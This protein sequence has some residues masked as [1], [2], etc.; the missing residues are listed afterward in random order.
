MRNTT[1]SKRLSSCDRSASSAQRPFH[2]LPKLALTQIIQGLE[3]LL[4]PQLFSVFGGLGSPSFSYN[5][6]LHMF[7]LS[8]SNGLHSAHFSR[9]RTVMRNRGDIPDCRYFKAL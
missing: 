5:T 4:F 7:T 6:L 1:L 8:L 3:I 2:V 9:T